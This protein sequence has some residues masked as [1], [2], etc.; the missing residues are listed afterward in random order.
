LIKHGTSV[1]FLL[2]GK[3]DLETA[4]RILD[5]IPKSEFLSALN[6]LNILGNLHGLE[7]WGMMGDE[8]PSTAGFIA[9]ARYRHRYRRER[10]GCITIE[11][12]G[13][14]TR[15]AIRIYDW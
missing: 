2:N 10:K 11:G 8:T 14:F 1:K 4:K 3:R 15:S 6:S 13:G 7:D 12:R 5:K 9:I